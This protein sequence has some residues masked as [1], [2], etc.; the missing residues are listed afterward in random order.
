[1]EVN[2]HA[3]NATLFNLKLSD[4]L[5]VMILKVESYV[6]SRPALAD[7]VNFDDLHFCWLIFF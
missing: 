1:M 5:G 3:V 2:P 6:S 4:L 7:K